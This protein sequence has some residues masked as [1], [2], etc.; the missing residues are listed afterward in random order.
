MAAI[1]DGEAPVMARQR[2]WAP[3][4]TVLDQGSVLLVDEKEENLERG[5]C[6]AATVGC[7]E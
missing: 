6:V 2:S 3:C 7:R 1:G 5:Y 4:W